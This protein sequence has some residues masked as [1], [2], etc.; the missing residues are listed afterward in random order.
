MKTKLL[1]LMA[2]C[3][4]VSSMAFGQ[5]RTIK[6]QVVSDTDGEPLTGAAIVQKGTSNG[7]VADVNGNF[8]LTVPNNSVLV[9]SYIGFTTQ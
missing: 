7:V 5:N 2:V 9:V 8:T 1:F 3:L 4:M 6:G